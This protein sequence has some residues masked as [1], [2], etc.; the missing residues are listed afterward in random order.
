M[1]AWQPA[2]LRAQDRR[3]VRATARQMGYGTNAVG[4]VLVNNR[5]AFRIREP[6]G[7]LS[8]YQRAQ[9]VA[10]R[11][12]ELAAEGQLQAE[13]LAIRQVS[14]TTGIY[15][16]G[17]LIITADRR[18]AFA[19]RTTPLRLARTWRDNLSEAMIG[20]VAAYRQGDY[21]VAQWVETELDTKL[22]PIVTVGSAGSIGVA[23]VSGPENRVREVRAVAQLATDYQDTARIRILVP[24]RTENVVEN[25]SRVPQVAVTGIGGIRF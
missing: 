3:N 15:A 6:A 17:E 16:D 20:R 4:E 9:A 21:R 22:V 5:V 18:H 1:V 24:I 7:G 10:R 11:L 14:G 19:N 12:N 8:P 23:Q 25:L 2:A 13:E